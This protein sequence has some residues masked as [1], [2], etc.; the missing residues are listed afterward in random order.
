[1]V[2][3]KLV[4]TRRSR[5]HLLALYKYISEDSPQNALK[6]INDIV[7]ATEKV[8]SNPKYYNPDKY[9]IDNDGSYR[10]FEN[11]VIGLSIDISTM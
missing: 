8:I 9:K 10:A 3:N 6:V 2:K 11:I 4:W 1:M 5:Q 7:A